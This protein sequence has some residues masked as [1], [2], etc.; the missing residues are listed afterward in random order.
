MGGR[1][2]GQ[3]YC[4]FGMITSIFAAFSTTSG[5]SPPV[6]TDCWGFEANSPQQFDHA[7]QV[8][9]D[10]RQKGLHRKANLAEVTAAPE[11]VHLPG[12]AKFAFD[13]AA[14]FQTLLIL[15]GLSQSQ[16]DVF[17]SVLLFD[18]ATKKI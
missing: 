14:L 1:V 17:M 15:G 6:E 16:P 9:Y 10:R 18:I 12:F 3:C 7:F 4:N 8:E 2:R 11:P 13:F 5:T